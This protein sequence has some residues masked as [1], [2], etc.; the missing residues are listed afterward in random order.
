MNS[1]PPLGILLFGIALGACLPLLVST[2]RGPVR[3]WLRRWLG[4]RWFG[5]PLLRLDEV[6][7]RQSR[8]S[9]PAGERQL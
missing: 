9:A 6:P 4:I 2:L 1:I 5:A 7:S 3:G 8:P